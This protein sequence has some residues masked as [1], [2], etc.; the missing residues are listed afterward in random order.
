MDKILEEWSYVRKLSTDYLKH[1]EPEQL[2]L[3]PAK[4]M[5]PMWK[6]FRHI[7]RVQENY[8][9]ALRT[10]A[11]SFSTVASDSC[12]FIDYRGGA[13]SSELLEYLSSCDEAMK[14]ALA[15]FDES[16]TIDWFGEK[17]GLD[18]HLIRL[19]SHETLHHGQWI[20]FGKSLDVAFPSSWEAWGV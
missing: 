17:V 4:N 18:L 10:G 2:L 3:S 11:I 19:V 14:K 1:L 5:G 9:D 16:Q 15:Q 6:Q 12:G 7:A 8:T 13:S 20:M